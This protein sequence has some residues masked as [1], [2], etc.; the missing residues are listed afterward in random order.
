MRR[1]IQFLRG[2]SVLAV[3]FYH[4]GIG[5][6]ANGYLGVDVFFVISGYLITGG[7]LRD[8]KSGEYRFS[9]FYL[10]RARRLLPALYST[11]AVTTLLAYVFLLDRQWPDYLSQLFG[12]MTFSSNF[13]F[14]CRLATLPMRRKPSRYFMSGLYHWRSNTISSF[15]SYCISRPGRKAV[16]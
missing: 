3:L 16:P 4:S 15:L 8:L 11:L 12:A 13:F 7:I 5:Y 1:D 10:K 2:V 14:P 6:F 9:V